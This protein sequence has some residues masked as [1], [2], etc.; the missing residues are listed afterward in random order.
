LQLYCKHTTANCRFLAPKG[1]FYQMKT[2]VLTGASKGIGRA[3][4]EKFAAEAFNVAI[5][6][7]NAKN[8]E[9]FANYLRQQY[10]VTVLALPVDVTDKNQLQTFANQI[11]STFGRVDVLVNNAGVF[12]PGQINNEAD[13]VFEQQVATNLASVYYFTR[14]LLPQIMATPHS[15]IF[16]MCSTAS[17]TPYTNGGS[18][19]ITKYALYGMTKVLREELKDKKVKVTAVLP[20]AT[21]TASWEGVDLPA[22]RFIPAKDIADA[23]WSAYNT[24]PSTVVEDLLIRPQL[25]DI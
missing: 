24:S 9:E 6:A 7:R 3:I 19:C 17:I 20:G 12:L 25:G 16:N 14:M 23:V 5:C 8:I 11:I 18:Y 10:K 2:I 22:D 15:H 1:Y 13:G 21:L 4:A